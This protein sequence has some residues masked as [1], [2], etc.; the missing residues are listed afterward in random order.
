MRCA[1]WAWP[2][3][4]DRDVPET[5][6]TPEMVEKDLVFVGLIGMIDPPRQEVKPALQEGHPGRYPHRQ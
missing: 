6:L 5:D 4:L 2:Y 3:R 1:C